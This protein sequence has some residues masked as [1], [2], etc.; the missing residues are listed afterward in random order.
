[1]IQAAADTLSAILKEDPPEFAEKA[2]GVTPAL[3]AIVRRCLEKQPADRFHSAHDLA[4]AL[5][6]VSESTG[7]GAHVAPAPTN[8]GIR[9]ITRVAFPAVPRYYLA[10]PTVTTKAG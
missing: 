3:D 1:M 8:A 6:A 5:R 10:A 7:S 4:L 2:R 9:R